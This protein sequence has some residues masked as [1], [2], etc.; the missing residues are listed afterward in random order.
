MLKIPANRWDRCGRLKPL[1]S[2]CVHRLRDRTR[3]E[4]WGRPPASGKDEARARVSSPGTKCA[5]PTLIWDSKPRTSLHDAS[6]GDWLRFLVV[7]L[8]SVPSF[9][10]ITATATVFN[11]I[12]RQGSPRRRRTKCRLSLCN[13]VLRSLTVLI[14]LPSSEERLP[15]SFCEWA[16]WSRSV[17]PNSLQPHGL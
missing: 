11:L 3:K 9:V 4:L 7:F 1:A 2:G 15:P 12:P 16:K 10:W 13:T 5:K 6:A 14:L 17:V 8:H